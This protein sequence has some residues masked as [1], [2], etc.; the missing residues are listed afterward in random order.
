MNMSKSAPRL[1]R[2]AI[3]LAGLLMLPPFIRSAPGQTTPAKADMAMLVP[4][5]A[6]GYVHVKNLSRILQCLPPELT[7]RQNT[8]RQGSTDKADSQPSRPP[9]VQSLDQ[10]IQHTIGLDSRRFVKQFLG[11]EFALAWG[12][13]DR[14]DQF[15]LICRPKQPDVTTTLPATDKSMKSGSTLNAGAF[16]VQDG[17][18]RLMMVDDLLILGTV[19]DQPDQ[20]LFPAIQRQLRPHSRQGSLSQQK[21]FA[22]RLA[23][24]GGYDAFVYLQRLKLPPMGLQRDWR[25]GL[26]QLLRQL[27]GIALAGNFQPGSVQVRMRAEVKGKTPFLPVGQRLNHDDLRTLPKETVL[28][29]STCVAPSLW[30]KHFKQLN[31]SARDPLSAQYVA[32]LEILVPDETLRA[33]M[34][35]A[36]GPQ[37][38]LLVIDRPAGATAAANELLPRLALMV[39]VQDPAISAE[40]VSQTMTTLAM[41]LNIRQLQ[42]ETNRFISVQA[43]SHRGLVVRRLDLSTA[44]GPGLTQEGDKKLMLAWTLMDNNL[45]LATAEDTICQIIDA[46]MGQADQLGDWPGWSQQSPQPLEFAFYLKPEGLKRQLQCLINV[47]DRTGRGWAYLIRTFELSSPYASRSGP[48]LGIAAKDHNGAVNVTAVVPGYP[49]WGKLKIG[50]AITAVNGQPLAETKPSADLHRKVRALRGK[51]IKLNVHRGGKTSTVTINLPKTLLPA[52]ALA[53]NLKLL[54]PLL[55]HTDTISFLFARQNQNLHATLTLT[56]AKTSEN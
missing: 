44:L 31:P 49:A 22:D 12:G 25:G 34:L 16:H 29:Y 15:A 27:E 54:L 50:D 23:G 18:L 14:P 9:R 47:F 46:R 6:Q 38:T 8:A 1:W 7:G 53:R 52:D 20:G 56:W 2:P 11:N 35:D 36:L 13:W 5:W 48:L 30:Y 28:A 17:H 42:Q 40:I 10:I 37:V 26:V 45:I 19:D 33:A 3:Y 43:R 21:V 51:K 4:Q 32:I 39:Q 24:I 41:L 55:K